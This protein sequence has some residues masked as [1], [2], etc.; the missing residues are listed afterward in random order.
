MWRL[1]SWSQILGCLATD[2][3]HAPLMYQVRYTQCISYTNCALCPRSVFV[4]RGDSQNQQQS[5]HFSKQQLPADLSNGKAMFL[6]CLQLARVQSA[7]Q[8]TVC[9]AKLMDY[10][11]GSLEFVVYRKLYLYCC[12][13][14]NEYANQGTVFR[15]TSMYRKCQHL[16]K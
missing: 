13:N 9:K 12:F 11:V 1:R 5:S 3:Q 7:T 2:H 14:F 16:W 6:Y 15:Y 8:I 4:C 10:V